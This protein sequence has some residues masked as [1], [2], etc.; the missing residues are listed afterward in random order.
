MSAAAVHRRARFALA[1]P[2]NVEEAGLKMK[3]TANRMVRTH[4]VAE[5]NR[6]FYAVVLNLDLLFEFDFLRR[7]LRSS[8]PICHDITMEIAPQ[9]E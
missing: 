6:H 8:R 9:S 2:E 5:L 4:S 3:E 7:R 1:Q